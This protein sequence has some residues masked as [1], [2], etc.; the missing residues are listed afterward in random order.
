MNAMKQFLRYFYFI[1]LNSRHI[2]NFIIITPDYT[3][4]YH[5]KLYKKLRKSKRNKNN[6]AVEARGTPL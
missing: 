4:L 3:L 2:I 1:V 6:I 5:R